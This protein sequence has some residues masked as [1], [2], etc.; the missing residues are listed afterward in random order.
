[1]NAEQ[2]TGS[3]LSRAQAL[4]AG[5]LPCFPCKANKQPACP[6]GFHAATTDFIE[7][8]ALWRHYPGQLIGVATGEASGI[9]VLDIDAPRHPEAAVWLQRHGHQL[10]RTRSHETRSAGLHLL[11]CISRAC[12][13]G[14]DARC[15]V[16]MGEPMADM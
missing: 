6:G 11:F 10:P 3:V 5:G 12:G 15:R 9:D 7:L 8:R 4:A 1:M 14:L 16:S 13:A 2:I